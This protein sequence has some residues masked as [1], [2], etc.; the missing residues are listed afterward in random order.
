MDLK[1]GVYELESDLQLYAREIRFHPLSVIYGPGKNVFLNTR[2]LINP[3]IDTS[4]NNVGTH[5]HGED[6]GHIE[7]VIDKGGSIRSSILLVAMGGHATQYSCYD[8]TLDH[9][10]L[11]AGNGG[12]G[13]R[14]FINAYHD[15]MI[16]KLPVLLNFSRFR[17]EQL[18]GCCEGSIK[19]QTR[20]KR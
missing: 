11:M 19:F 5:Q 15:A 6:A 10:R 13:G 12:N 2:L 17:Y 16:N 1:P 20:P 18:E 14:I 8:N 3:W 4:A 7:L 9:W